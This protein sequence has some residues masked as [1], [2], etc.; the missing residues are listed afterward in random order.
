MGRTQAGFTLLEVLVAL[1]IMAFSLGALYHSLTANVRVVREM[2]R[3]VE[4]GIL[5]QSL[6]EGHSAVFPGGLNEQGELDDGLNWRIRSSPYPASSERVAL[7]P[8]HR[9]EIEV[10]W[11]GSARRVKLVTL[12]PEQDAGA[13]LR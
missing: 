10:G 11:R 12:L 3:V 5:A 9:V 13:T 1:A 6:L 2:A 4:A 7:M 8:L